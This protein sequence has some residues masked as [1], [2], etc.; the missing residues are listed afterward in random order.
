MDKILDFL[1]RSNRYKH[2]IGGFLVGICALSGQNAIYAA[3]VAASCLELKDKLHGC[4]WDWVDWIILE[5]FSFSKSCICQRP[6]L[7]ALYA[8]ARII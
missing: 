2:L 6:S 7:Y 1:K 3:A 8:L 4:M 5:T